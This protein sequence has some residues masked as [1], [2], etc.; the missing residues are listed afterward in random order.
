MQYADSAMCLVVD[1]IAHCMYNFS[2]YFFSGLSAFGFYSKYSA[3]TWKD[4]DAIII[5]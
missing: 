1:E 3:W 4:V 5:E 2:L